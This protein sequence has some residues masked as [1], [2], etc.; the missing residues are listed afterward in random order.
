MNN[1]KTDVHQFGDF[2]VHV[3]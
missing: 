2:T 3:F 1:E